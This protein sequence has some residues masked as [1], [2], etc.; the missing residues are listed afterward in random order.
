LER[1]GPAPDQ[2][3]EALA[4]PPVERSQRGAC[5][6]QAVADGTADEVGLLLIVDEVL[7]RLFQKFQ[8][9]V[10]Q[11]CFFPLAVMVFCLLLYEDSI[12]GQARTILIRFRRAMMLVPALPPVSPVFPFGLAAG[13]GKQTGPGRE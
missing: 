12:G 6:E 2:R 13:A 9:P 11:G 8:S 1:D 10:V 7:C 5:P 4:R 3:P